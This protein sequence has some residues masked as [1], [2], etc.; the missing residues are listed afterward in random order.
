[1]IDEQTILAVISSELSQAQGSSSNDSLQANREAALSYYLGLPN[2]KEVKGKSSVVSTDVADAIEWIMPQVIKALTQNNEVVRFDPSGADDEAQAELESDFVYDILMKDNSGFIVLHQFIKDALMQKNGILKAY[3]SKY[4]EVKKESYTGLVDMQIQM[5]L[6][7]PGVEL[8]SHTSTETPEGV[9]HDVKIGR[10]TTAGS[11]VVEAVAPE[12]FR[13]ATSHNSILLKDCRFCAH[14]EDKTVSDLIKMGYPRELVESIQGSDDE[15]FRSNYRFTMQGENYDTN[16]TA[17][18]ESQRLITVAECYTYMDIDDDGIGE[19][20]KITVAGGDNPTQIL[21]IEEIDHCPFVSGTAILMSHKFSGLSIY[22]RLCQIQDHKTSLWRNTMDNIYLQN[23]QR[24]G[25]LDGQ[26]NL[27]DLL[28]SRP[29]GVIRMK[30][31]D[32]LVPVVTP[33]IG[34]AAYRMLDYLDMT[35]AGRVGVDPNGEVN[36][37]NVGDR[38]GSQGVDRVM[39][40]KEELVNLM[41]RVIAE[42]GLKPLCYLIRDLAIQHMDSVQHFRYKEAW[43]D[44]NPSTWNRRLRSTVRVGVG[45]GDRRLLLEGAQQILSLQEKMLMNP[46]QSFVT[47]NQIYNGISFAAKQL[48]IDGIGRFFLSPDSDEGKKFA[49]EQQASV[50][51]EK[52][53]GKQMAIMAAQA[54][55]KLAEAEQMKAQAQFQTNQIKLDNDKLKNQMDAIKAEKDREIA[56]LRE[57]LAANRQ[58][59]EL[60]F[61]YEQLHQNTALKL[62]ELEATNNRELSAQQADN[63]AGLDEGAGDAE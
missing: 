15:A 6:A 31:V 58:D 41:I 57:Q 32:A 54:Q 62:T 60:G 36:V 18:D 7:E 12:H 40:A 43:H 24:M 44:V 63:E 48:G 27:D 53:D 34:D 25:V 42:T 23:N 46:S 9:L 49:E 29:G 8:V 61:K 38:I 17:V 45:T 4:D 3:Y 22:D 20:V 10:T 14:V 47:P 1:M 59:G 2:G 13:V 51:K 11:I 30:S 21:D 50:G 52:E 55:I 28:L 16:D 19:Y 26:V 33:Q 37:S 5:L 56:V 35:R 39:T